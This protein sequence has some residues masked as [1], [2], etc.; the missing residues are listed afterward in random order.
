MSR[1]IFICGNALS[2]IQFQVITAS[3]PTLSVN[4]H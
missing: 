4:F 2:S 3:G 1:V